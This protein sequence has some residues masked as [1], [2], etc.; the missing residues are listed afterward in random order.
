VVRPRDLDHPLGEV[1]ARHEGA[2]VPEFRRQI[3][4]AATGV[5]HGKP[6][7]VAGEL[8][9]D[10]VGIQPPVAVPVVADLDAPVIGEK[11]PAPA[12]FLQR[13]VA[14]RPFSRQEGVL[15]SEGPWR[16]SP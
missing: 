7:D 1:H 9:Q 16:D 4:R 10:G 14:H 8:P 2:A 3:P 5:E 11:V 13:A 12:S 15:L 6:A